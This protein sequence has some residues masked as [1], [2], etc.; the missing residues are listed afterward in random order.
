MKIKNMPEKSAGNMPEF[1]ALNSVSD[2]IVSVNDDEEEE[3]EYPYIKQ[4]ILDNNITIT[5][6]LSDSLTTTTT[7]NTNTNK[8][9][10][11]STNRSKIIKSYTDDDD[12]D[13]MNIDGVGHNYDPFNADKEG[14]EEDDDGG[15]WFSAVPSSTTGSDGTGK[16]GTGKGSSGMPVWEDE[17]TIGDITT[18]A[19]T[20][21][22]GDGGVYTDTFGLGSGGDRKTTV[23]PYTSKLT[24]SDG[25]QIDVID[26]DAVIANMTQTEKNTSSKKYNTIDNTTTNTNTINTTE[27][28]VVVQSKGKGKDKS[29]PIVNKSDNEP[30]KL[31]KTTTG[32]GKRKAHMVEV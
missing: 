32:T 20:S 3:E 6:L 29:V 8:S 26:V 21:G 7:A 28:V 16:G 18:V 31:N 24:L 19:H 15:E 5:S 10:V 30:K 23:R 12:N 25:A 17:D 14:E 13:A 2:R 9:K 11:I 1:S 22:S 27:A 4:Y